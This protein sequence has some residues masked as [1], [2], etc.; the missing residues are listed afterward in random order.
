MG[1][2]ACVE[3]ACQ[4]LDVVPNRVA[5]TW[6]KSSYSHSDEDACVEIADHVPD[7]VPIRDSKVPDGPA[8]A[9]GAPAWTAFVAALTADTIPPP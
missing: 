4:F 7:I 1:Q 8:I 3:V 2:D 6:R 9:A 5:V